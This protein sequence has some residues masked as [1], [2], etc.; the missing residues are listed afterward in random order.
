M[1]CRT[2]LQEN[3]SDTEPNFVFQK[4]LTSQSDC[5]CLGSGQSYAR[6]PRSSHYHSLVSHFQLG[7]EV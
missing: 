6:V 1:L 5:E 3:A 4:V 2:A 7:R